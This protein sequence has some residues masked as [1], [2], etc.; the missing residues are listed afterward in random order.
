[1]LKISDLALPDFE[2]GEVRSTAGQSRWRGEIRL[3]IV[4]QRRFSSQLS[5]HRIELRRTAAV[6]LRQQPI[7]IHAAAANA[8][9]SAGSFDLEGV[10]RLWRDHRHACD[11]RRNM[12]AQ[13]I[14][15]L[16]AQASVQHRHPLI[17]I[18]VQLHAPL[19]HQN[20]GQV[21]AGIESNAAVISTHDFLLIVAAM[22][23][24]TSVDQSRFQ[25]EAQIFFQPHAQIGFALRLI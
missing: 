8:D 13:R 1:M 15:T 25:T 14:H 16:G 6:I 20:A 17:P 7:H 2:I 23:P 12:H 19:L 10:W 3:Q 22:P 11:S 18:R 9:V 5:E 4:R 24:L 21:D